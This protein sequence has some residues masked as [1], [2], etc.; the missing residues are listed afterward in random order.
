MI[1]LPDI[2]KAFK[3]ENDFYHSSD[4]SRIAK[5]LAHY[6]LFKRAVTLPGVIMEFGVFKGVSLVRLAIFRSLFSN[7]N[8]IKIVGFD[9]FDKF[10][11]ATHEN[12]RKHRD[13]FIKEAGNLSISEHQLYESLK[14]RGLDT[15][16]ELIKGDI[17][18]TCPKYVEEHPE[19]KISLLHID[20]DLYE[21]TK[22]IM[23][24]LYTKVVNDGIIIFDDYATFGGETKAIDEFFK[25]K[26]VN[27]QK[28]PFILRPCYMIKK[29]NS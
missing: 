28:F 19:L 11:E 29:V 3:Y 14:R 22:V 24:Q 26:F 10:P 1:E 2:K 8:S 23:H 21:P 12:D 13:S 18:K 27:I 6:E 4:S 25:D 9:T 7:A 16:V 15:N 20:V 17:C 5:I